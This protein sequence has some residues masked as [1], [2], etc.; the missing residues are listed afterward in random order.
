MSRIIQG[1]EY[2]S[3]KTGNIIK[4]KAF[5]YS[6]TEKGIMPLVLY[7]DYMRLRPDIDGRV[8]VAKEMLDFYEEFEEVKE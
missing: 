6:K 5:A 4:V 2:K 8:I 1:Y 7:K 3:K